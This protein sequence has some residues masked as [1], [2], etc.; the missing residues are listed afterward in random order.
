MNKRSTRLRYR[1]LRRLLRR[2]SR[3]L[4]AVTLMRLFNFQRGMIL[5]LQRLANF[6]SRCLATI[7]GAAIGA[8]FLLAAPKAALLTHVSEASLACAAIIGS[9]LVLL[10]TLSVI[11]AQKAAEAFSAAILKIYARDSTLMLVFVLL[12]VSCMSSVFFGT[13]WR[14]GLPP[15]QSLA[16][17]FVLLG[18]SLDGLRLFYTRTL[19]LLI[20]GTAVALV[21]KQC[22]RAIAKVRRTVDRIARILQTEH[23]PPGTQ[24]AS[25][26]LL[27]AG[28][29][30]AAGLR[31]WITQLDEF[32]HKAVARGD[33]EAVNTILT[34]MRTI[35]AQYIDARRTSVVLVPDWNNLFAGGSSDISQVLEP[36][37]ESIRVICQRAA[38]GENELVVR[39][40]IQTLGA[41]TTYAMGVIHDQSGRRQTTPL[42]Y[43]PCFYLDLCVQTAIRA[44]LPDAVLA[45][46]EIL[47]GI[48]LTAAKDVDTSTVEAKALETLFT[49]AVSGYAAPDS[50]AAFPA[51]QALLH[52]AGHDIRIR[53]YRRQPTLET[54]LRY[55]SL[56]APL[57]VA[58]ETAGKRVMQTFPAYSLGFEANIAALLEAVGHA[59]QPVDRR[60]R[61]SPFREFLEAAEDIVHHY[62]EVA[63]TDFKNTLLLKWVI[64][65]IVTC[66]KVHIALMDNPPAGG[67]LFADEIDDRL[68][69][70]IHAVTFFYPEQIP[71]PPH[72]DDAASGLAILGMMLLSCNRL[73][74]AQACAEVIGRIAA[75]CAV[76]QPRPYDPA[77]LYEKLEILG[78]AAEALEHAHA[79]AGFRALI[80]K[81]PA[82]T[83]ADWTICRKEIATRLS[84][85]N[86]SLARFDP[87]YALP[88][89]PVAM[90]RAVLVRR[91]AP[92][93]KEESR[94][95]QG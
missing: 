2:H 39:Q 80:A 90:L 42:A 87:G 86:D 43:S 92:E 56:L 93:A 89:D 4:R 12:T 70:Y 37:H 1:H 19:Y 17:Q 62:R 67:E 36:I 23:G 95:R 28:S 51:V 61:I 11:P 59:A 46:V 29:Q 44:N 14:L 63:K 88:D 68:Q 16:I 72:A 45:A 71:F 24:A 66:A 77:D 40:C 64:D 85:L 73:D 25:R 76:S 18:I 6:G 21:L 22:N 30:I 69:W 54:V 5:R 35:S 83:D 33:T 9:A 84:Q 74:S 27:F 82:V 32:A 31:G 7:V 34:A 57:E 78:R 20:P 94:Q 79:A 38:K 41:M 60:R 26:A 47:Q 65:S 50:V 15:L 91:T 53:G 10:L 8:L 13:G 48:L 58:M 49:I 52:A 75:N 3:R 55:L 81:P